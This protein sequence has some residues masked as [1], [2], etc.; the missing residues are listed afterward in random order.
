MPLAHAH[1]H[2]FL[3]RPQCC[4]GEF[5]QSDEGCQLADVREQFLCWIIDAYSPHDNMALWYPLRMDEYSIV[6]VHI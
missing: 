6:G 5:V 4:A 3:R 1:I 2:E